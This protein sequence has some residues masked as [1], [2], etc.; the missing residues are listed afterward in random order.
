MN[1]KSPN[2]NTGNREIFEVAMSFFS[3]NC[4]VSL[5]QC[6][7]IHDKVFGMRPGR[8]LGQEILVGENLLE[9]RF[10]RLGGCPLNGIWNICIENRVV[11]SKYSSDGSISRDDLLVELLLGQVKAE[12]SVKIEV[13]AHGREWH[14]CQ[15][16]YEYKLHVVGSLSD[17]V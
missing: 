7:M 17:R 6:D 12:H 4:L 13:S 9:A 3:E 14:Q 8:R 2:E 11:R 5:S 15:Q 1:Q 16:E 10:V